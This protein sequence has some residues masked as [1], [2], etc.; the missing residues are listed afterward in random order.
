M[1]PL[2]QKFPAAGIR[3]TGGLSASLH[4]DMSVVPAWLNPAVVCEED[5]SLVWP[6]CTFGLVN[7]M[8]LRTQTFVCTVMFAV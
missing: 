8:L 5:M 1:I 3:E 7:L 6:G 4:D 2:G